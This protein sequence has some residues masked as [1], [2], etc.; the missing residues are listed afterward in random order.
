[1][2]DWEMEREKGPGAGVKKDSQVWA[3]G[4]GQEG[5]TAVK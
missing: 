1:M 3:C 2:T 5:W 4:S